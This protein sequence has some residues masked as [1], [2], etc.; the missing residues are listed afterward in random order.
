MGRVTPLAVVALLVGALV[1]P[2]AGAGLA[3]D[4][5]PVLEGA[6]RVL[7]AGP[8]PA[9]GVE[10]AD[11]GVGPALA[12]DTASLDSQFVTLVAAERLESADDSAERRQV[13]RDAIERVA[14]RLDRL[15]AAERRAYRGHANGSLSEEDV[16]IRLARVQAATGPLNA[17]F[18]RVRDRGD[19]PATLARRLAT[20]SAEHRTLLGP[21]RARVLGALRGNRGE[22]RVFVQ[23]SG[24]GV[25]LATVDGGTYRREAFR[26]DN[27]DIDVS[28]E[29]DGLLE[30]ISH[31]NSLYPWIADN[32]RGFDARNA[33]IDTSGVH[34]ITRSHGL[35]QTRVAIDGSTREVFREIHRLDTERMPTR[36]PVNATNASVRV[37]VA[38]TY[39]GGPMRVRVVE[40]GS[41]AGATR[42]FVNGT[43][44]GK[45]GSDGV[46]WTLTPAGEF[47]VTAGGATPATVRVGG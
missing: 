29:F 37:T 41:P 39:A 2:V 16:L 5:Q 32:T 12:A 38:R 22:V 4:P 13:A 45:T 17:T 28:S 47:T 43:P 1:V 21:V 36:E 27:R 9:S 19:L 44:V 3:V 35:G 10:T 25:V 33:D 46:L 18:A 7:P 6:P 26:A 24:T 11:P 42:V 8:S 34:S 20:V 40:D 15:R 31:L 30:L 14:D 23:S